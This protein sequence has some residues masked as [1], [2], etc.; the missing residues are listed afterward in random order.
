[1]VTFTQG[2]TLGASNLSI[3]VR[4]ATGA[5]VDPTLINYTIFHVT[6]QIPMKITQAYEYDLHQPQN[7]AGGPPLPQENV[8]LAGCPQQVPT[9]VSQGAYY[10]P[11]TIPT[12]WKGVYRLVWNIQMYPDCPLDT[13]V[14]VFVV[15]GIDPANPGFEAPSVIIAV[16]ESIVNSGMTTPA[17][18]A[19]AVMYVRE[20]LSDTNPDRNYHFRPPTPS[21]VVAGYNTRVGYIWLDASILMHLDTA[22]SMLNWYNPMNITSYTLDTIPLDWGRIAA[23]GAAGFCLKMEANRWGAD[24]FNY[25]L[26]GVSLDIN[27]ADLY[28]GLGESYL[29]QFNTMAP[30]LTANRPMSVG[31][32]QQRW[33]LG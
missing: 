26:N 12:T 16:P 10:V 22:I 15:Q 14:E 21:R 32:R 11:I 2:M 31:L 3:L 30:L 33:L 18:F 25:S 6:D 13:V 1:M 20:H 24:Q 29:T 23:I 17:Q 19:K 27:K 28:N 5:L 4:D 8:Q 7:M 9:R